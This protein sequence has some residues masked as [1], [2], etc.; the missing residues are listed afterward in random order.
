MIEVLVAMVLSLVVVGGITSMLVRSARV[1]QRD[2]EWAFTQQQARTGLDSMTTEIRQAWSILSTSPNSVELDVTM[3]GVAEHVLYE[4]GVAQPRTSYLECVRVQSPAGSALPSLS[5]GT[6]VVH[7]MLNGTASDPVFS[8][9]PDPV[10][11]YYMTAS[12]EVP[13]SGG[14][15]GGLNHTIVISDGVLMRNEYVGD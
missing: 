9:A 6:V 3:G 14:A 11:P 10:A 7:N 13:A 12:V 15:N 5:A 1:E 4:C 2:N 8:F